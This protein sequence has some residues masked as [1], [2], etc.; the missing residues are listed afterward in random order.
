C[1]TWTNSCGA[2]WTRSHGTPQMNPCFCGPGH[3]VCHY[4]YMWS[5]IYQTTGLK[6]EGMF[7]TQNFSANHS[8]KLTARISTN[9]SSGSVLFYAANGLAQSSLNQCGDAI[10]TVSSSNKQL[11]GQYN[12]Y[13]NGTITVEFTFNANADYA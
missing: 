6:G 13:T 8:Y 10:P 1:P 9:I 3:T 2:G 4:A 11:I 5:T 7:T 12:G